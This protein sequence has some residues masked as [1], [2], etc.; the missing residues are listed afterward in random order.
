MRITPTAPVAA[1]ALLITAGATGLLAGCRGTPPA[2]DFVEA[3]ATPADWMEQTGAMALMPLNPSLDPPIWE[4]RIVTAAQE[5]LILSA[6]GGPDGAVR[7][8][9]AEEEWPEAIDFGPRFAGAK[10]LGLDRGGTLLYIEAAQH[11]DGG[12]LL[13]TYN[14]AERAMQDVSRLPAAD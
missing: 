10:R 6:V 14:L 11:E 8:S 4:R 5:I 2:T 7:L 1:A 3:A 13:Y 12:P 9:G